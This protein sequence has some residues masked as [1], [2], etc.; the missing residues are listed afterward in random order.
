MIGSA[1]DVRGGISALV[2]VYFADGLFERWQAR[3]VATH[4]DGA[5]PAKAF[6]ALRAWLRVVPAMLAGRVALLHVHIA[7]GAS[8][9]RK[10]LFV[11]PAWALRIP[12]ILHM[13]GGDF[14]RFYASRTAAGRWLLRFIYA[15]A[16]TV[17]ALSP[18]WR[19]VIA[20]VVPRSRIAVIPNPVQVPPWQ[21]SLAGEPPTAV[22]LGVI[23][24]R[25]GV[26]D[27]LRAWPAVLE[28]VAAARLV[29]AGS[30]DWPAASRLARELGI[31][32]S[33]EAPGW[34]GGDEKAALLR[35]ACAFVLPSHFEAL[36]MSV[37]E[38]MACGVPIVATRVGG[39]PEAVGDEAGILVQPRDVQGLATALAAMLGE[40]STRIAAGNAARRR[41]ADLFS[42]AGIVPR[43]EALWRE[44]LRSPTGLPRHVPRGHA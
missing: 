4:C 12:F 15:R 23:E 20:S 40:R 13:H 35:R 6:Q 3:Y 18:Q 8:F 1:R 28:R 21:S 14:A 39:I 26:H 38:A 27:L 5:W 16:F 32:P 31:E 25:K 7:S 34:I 9:Y 17:I 11:L 22:F 42:T 2:N 10:A 43:V 44:A 33:I 41:A 24:E 36:P 29:I 19:E 37:L 30:G